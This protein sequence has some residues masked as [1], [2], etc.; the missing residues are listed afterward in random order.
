MTPTAP[1]KTPEDAATYLAAYD[2]LL[3]SWPVPFES[4][5]IPGRFGTTH[6]VVCGPEDAPPLVLLHGYMGTLLMWLPNVEDLSRHH[7]VYAIDL[8]GH[9]SRSVPVEPIRDAADFLSWLT[10]TLNRL[11]LDR[12]SLMGLSFGGW[13]ALGLA[14]KAPARVSKLVL[15]APAASLKPISKEFFVRAMATALVPRRYWFYALM[16]WMGLRPERMGVFGERVL[17]LMYAGRLFQ[18]PKETRLVMPAVYS[19]DELRSL[20]MPVLLLIGEDE[21]I[22]DAKEAVA[23]A[24]E[25]IPDLQADVVPVCSHDISCS[26][27][28]VVDERVL[29]FLDTGVSEVGA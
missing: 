18:M 13:L 2:S 11:R 3:A 29:E 25:L 9:P 21:V 28:A 4:L 22:Y 10:E 5:E 17:D 23:R 26:E 20:R 8:M 1:F 27:A 15:I 19:D 7:R 16:G 24:R 12:A 14:L 6:V